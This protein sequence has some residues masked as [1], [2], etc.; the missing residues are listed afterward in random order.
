M[1]PCRVLF[2]LCLQRHRSTAWAEH[3]VSIWYTGGPRDVTVSIFGLF[4]WLSTLLTLQRRRDRRLSGAICPFR[5]HAQR[6]TRNATSKG[7][8]WRFMLHDL[9]S[10][11]KSRGL[12]EGDR[13]SK[14]LAWILTLGRQYWRPLHTA[15][16]VAAGREPYLLPM[17]R[18]TQPKLERIPLVELCSTA[19]QQHELRLFA[20]S[21]TATMPVE[22]PLVSARQRDGSRLTVVAV[23]SGILNS[24]DTGPV[25]YKSTYLL[26][27]LIYAEKPRGECTRRSRCHG[28]NRTLY[29]CGPHAAILPEVSIR[30]WRC[31]FYASKEPEQDASAVCF[32]RQA[33]T[34]RC[35]VPSDI[36][37]ASADSSSLVE[38][39][40]DP[41]YEGAES[42][43]IRVDVCAKPAPVRETLDGTLQGEPAPGASLD[44]D[45]IA[46]RL[47]IC[48][49][50]AW[51][52]VDLERRVPG[53]VQT[54][55][56][57][58]RLLGA[59]GFT[60][61]DC[62]GSFADHP[63][64]LELLAVG[65]LKY[66]P[67]FTKAVS[68]LLDE[69]WNSDA[70]IGTT[71]SK[72][73]FMQELTL[74][75]CVL[76][77]RGTAGFVLIGAMDVFLAFGPSA[78]LFTPSTSCWTDS[79]TTAACCSGTGANGTRRVLYHGQTQCWQGS[80]TFSKCCLEY[81]PQ[82]PTESPWPAFLRSRS[83]DFWRA[84]GTVALGVCEF[85]VPSHLP[86]LQRGPD[87][88][89]L[90]HIWRPRSCEAQFY[91]LVNPWRFMSQNAEWVRLRP[92][93][94]RY[95]VDAETVRAMHFVNL[96]KVRCTERANLYG[97]AREPCNWPDF[98]L[99]WSIPGLASWGLQT[100]TSLRRTMS[101][102]T[103]SSRVTQIALG[104]SG[105]VL[106]CMKL[107]SQLASRVR[108]YVEIVL[109]WLN[110]H[111]CSDHNMLP[112][113]SFPHF[114]SN[115]FGHV[116]AS[117]LGTVPDNPIFK[118]IRGWPPRS[119]V[120]TRRKGLP[121]LP[122]I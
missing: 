101:G 63:E 26:E 11:L 86:R 118:A 102:S 40:A 44:G 39:Q 10:C 80:R 16:A 31:V 87:W 112:F 54:F 48:I 97:M 69:A 23:A 28:K 51:D 56:R 53:L 107:G 50:P 94:V 3:L 37:L 35:P 111:Y 24:A 7:S 110:L 42:W 91:H 72:G 62:D 84:V 57:Y 73:G 1:R 58:Y 71:G 122:V 113:L 25:P 46:S 121:Y 98:G 114:E 85:A 75:H 19:R 100:S 59:D 34:I 83:E 30:K 32:F 22:T 21:R 103:V 15:M 99:R 92:G 77:Y 52:M 20:S 41:P 65:R 119:V 104:R 88:S 108:A 61:Y 17:P 29:T 9:M 43:R 95:F 55:L 79:E 18:A 14:P 117:R 45:D 49:Q 64:I 68:Q 116:A 120:R 81:R 76:N 60:F 36:S 106:K 70:L 33:A 38:L 47:A 90:S 27:F 78:P 67:H 66:F 5:A 4:Q 96:H 89:F 12:F 2:A 105:E 82:A 8:L 13:P 74:N 109:Q 115:N 93:S 6:P